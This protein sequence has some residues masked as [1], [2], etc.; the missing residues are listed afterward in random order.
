MNKTLYELL[1]MKAKN[2]IFKSVVV[3]DRFTNEGY[4]IVEAEPYDQT[5]LNAV[6]HPSLYDK[7][8]SKIML[9]LYE[10]FNKEACWLIVYTD[11]HGQD[12]NL[13]SE[14]FLKDVFGL[15]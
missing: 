9:K 14:F 5:F 6:K 1:G 8:T 11:E 7:T 3:T 2:S 13:V 12:E 15:I 4:R 10:F